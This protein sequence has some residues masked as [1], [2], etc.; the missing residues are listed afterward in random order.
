MIGPPDSSFTKQYADCEI[1]YFRR[2]PFSLNN[3][4]LQ[5]RWYLN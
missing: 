2:G 3:E 5:F 1:I 4:I